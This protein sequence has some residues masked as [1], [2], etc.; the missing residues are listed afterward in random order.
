MRWLLVTTNVPGSSILVTLMKEPLSTSE[1]SVLTRATRRNIPEY[2]ILHSVEYDFEFKPQHGIG[3]NS[4]KKFSKRTV[5]FC[6]TTLYVALQAA[7]DI[8]K[9]SAASKF[10]SLLR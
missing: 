2:A 9:E 10:I 5:V 4:T 8:S 7:T 3:L 6:A 1:T